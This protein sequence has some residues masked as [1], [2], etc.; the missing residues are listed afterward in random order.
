MDLTKILEA[1]GYI[2]KDKQIAGT[3][4]M[5]FRLFD[6]RTS[7]Q[8][9]EQGFSGMRANDLWNRFEIWI[10]G[11]LDSTLSYAEF[12]L[13]PEKLNEWYCEVFGLKEINLDAAAQ[14]D[15]E[16]LKERKALLSEPEVQKAIDVLQSK[17]NK[18]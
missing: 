16:L 7:A 4:T 6:K 17:R 5:R 9:A 3:G 2:K 11:R 14:R 10:L 1:A 15:V 12:F 8:L 18:K 13:R